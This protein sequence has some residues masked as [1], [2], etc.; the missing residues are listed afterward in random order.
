MVNLTMEHINAQ[1]LQSNFDEIKLMTENRDID[2]LCVCETWLHS[3]TPDA[4][5]DIHNYNI[6]RNDKGRGGGVCI[7][8]KQSL[9]PKVI[10][11]KVI[12]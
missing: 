8:V 11:T 6:F 1:S 7:Y 9:N 10:D 5:V 3:I 2:I 4:Y 12:N